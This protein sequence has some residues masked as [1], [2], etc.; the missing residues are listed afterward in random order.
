[1]PSRWERVGWYFYDFGNSAFST[2]VVTVFL[3]PYLTTVARAAADAQGFV[4]PLG[5]PVRAGS[6]FPYV[7]PAITGWPR[8]SRS[9]SAAPRRSAALSTR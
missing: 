1:V 4:Y 6:F 9:S 3:G 8:P 5:V 2:T 7:S